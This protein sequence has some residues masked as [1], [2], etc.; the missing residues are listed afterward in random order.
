MAD[1]F[2]NTTFSNM[3]F[4]A[5]KEPQQKPSLRERLQAMTLPALLFFALERS[6]WESVEN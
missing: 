4:A 1:A 5:Q 3:P 6:P 2:L